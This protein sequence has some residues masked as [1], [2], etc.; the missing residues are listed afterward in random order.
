MQ[1]SLSWQWNG[2]MGTF[3]YE[4]QWFNWAAEEYGEEEIPSSMAGLITEN[5]EEVPIFCVTSYSITDKNSSGINLNWD[6][7]HFVS[8]SD[9]SNPRETLSGDYQLNGFVICPFPQKIKTTVN[10]LFRSEDKSSKSNQPTLALPSR[11]ATVVMT[12]DERIAVGL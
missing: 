9:I 5:G 8:L 2:R 12:L 11:K 4:F 7:D 1:Y 10:P 3:S 6:S